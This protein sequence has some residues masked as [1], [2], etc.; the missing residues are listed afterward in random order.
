V[1]EILHAALGDGVESSESVQ[2]RKRIYDSQR[3]G[4]AP[5]ALAL[6][7]GLM[8]STALII[9]L[10]FATVVAAPAAQDTVKDA[11]GK[12]IAKILDCNTCNDSKGSNCHMGA[13]QGFDAGKPCGTCLLDANFG[14]RIGYPFDMNITGKLQDASGKPLGGKFVSISLPNTWRIRTRTLDDGRFRLM[15]GATLPKDEPKKLQV[16]DLGV[17]TLSD[18]KAE[19]YSLFM[20]Q[21]GFKPCAPKK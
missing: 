1:I 15:L 3:S 21:D 19:E 9:F 11:Q 14:T 5:A 13:G 2:Y 17:R 20:L 6:A 4:G 8:R 12:T 18:S 16:V 7:E 10:L